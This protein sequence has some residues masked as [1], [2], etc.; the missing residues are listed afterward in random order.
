MAAAVLGAVA[1]VDD[2]EAWLDA[3]GEF[4]VRGVDAGIKDVY[5]DPATGA[6]V[7]VAVVERRLALVDTIQTPLRPPTVVVL[8]QLY[9]GGG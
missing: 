7:V 8:E 4:L 9:D 3:T 5:G 2:V 1:V 6:L